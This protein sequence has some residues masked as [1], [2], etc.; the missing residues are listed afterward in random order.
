MNNLEFDKEID[1]I[2]IMDDLDKINEFDI[3]LR[4][5]IDRDENVKL[6]AIKFIQIIF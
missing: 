6:D 3:K 1:Y 2:L 4:R 5:I